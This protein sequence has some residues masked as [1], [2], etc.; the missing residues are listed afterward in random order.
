MKEEF[1][2]WIKNFILNKTD[3]DELQPGGIL[4]EILKVSKNYD[5]IEY[6]IS[7]KLYDVNESNAYCV[8][9]LHVVCGGDMPDK[10]AKKV[11]EVLVNE[12]AIVDVV[13]FHGRT[14]LILAINNDKLETSLE[15]LL[16][17]AHPNRISGSL[18][19]PLILAI[20][21]SNNILVKNLVR[22]GADF[23]E[24]DDGNTP[25]SVAKETKN[26]YIQGFL[27]GHGACEAQYDSSDESVNP[28]DIEDTWYF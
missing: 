28:D 20:R 25:L 23:N 2:Q 27:E 13:D 5:L 17:G 26:E 6:I 12:G 18:I 16:Q 1:D 15:L 3:N 22:L 21:M 10:I 9:P 8:T 14:P 7:T 19:S 4:T 24:F 11:V